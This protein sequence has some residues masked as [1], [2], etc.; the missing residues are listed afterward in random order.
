MKKTLSYLKKTKKEVILGPLF[1]M[2]EVCFELC[3]P[4]IVSQ[5]V[6]KGIKGEGGLIYI[7][8]MCCVLLIF[9]CLG[10]TSTI[11]AQYFSA[12][13]ACK[14]A[15]N[16]RNDLFKKI[17]SLQYSDLDELGLSTLV[18][19]M[20][21][22]VNQVQTGV[23][24]TLRLLLRSP[25]VIIGAVIV[26]FTISKEV[27]LV[28]LCTV[29]TLFLVVFLIMYFSIPLFNKSQE[30]LDR[31]VEL[32]RENLVGVRVIRAFNKQEQEIKTYQKENNTLFKSQL[33]VGRLS[34]LINPLT[35]AL[36]NIF[37]IVLIYV[38]GLNVQA[39]N[40][41]QGDSIALY[42]LSSQILVETIKFASLIITVSRSIASSNRIDKILSI[43]SKYDVHDYAGGDD[44]YII[45][46]NHVSMSY[47]KGDKYSLKDINFKVKKGQTVGIIGGTGSGKTT[48]IN[49]M[50]HFY[51]INQGTI[52]FEGKD[53]ASYPLEYLHDQ[54]SLVPQKAKLFAGTIKENLL[55]GNKDATDEDLTRAIKASQ[56][57]DIIKKKKDGINEI[58]EQNG[59]N[60]SGGQ[61]Q[62][63]C[64]ARALVKKAKIL[65]LDDSSSALDYATDAKL[66]HA[67]LN[68]DKSLTTFIISQ[69]TSSLMHCDQILVLDNGELVGVGTHEELLKN[70][71][72]YQ[73]I[74]NSQ[75]SSEVKENEK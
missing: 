55:W 4:L 26:S 52:Y 33:F 39:G 56:S 8:L 35:Y 17:Q 9:A 5:I 47:K 72:V 22:D 54:I 27:G 3:V 7:L 11:I 19:R 29:P 25:A 10:L 64:I 50:N 75:F 59:N 21:S 2:L 42:N 41:S 37:I 40:L 65:I 73:E 60:F 51:D 14:L 15:T 31:V 28:F 44:N 20:T 1:K 69:R 68:F 58:V 16:L 36:I 62:R 74:H 30:K 66:R 12:K 32:T 70:C 18:T 34:T 57:E 24:M 61:K 53:I 38:S 45:E 23:N 13:A 67:L 71:E 46:F 63:L 48:L 43:E 6:D 49:V